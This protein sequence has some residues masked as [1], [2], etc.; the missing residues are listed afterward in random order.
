MGLILFGGVWPGV[1]GR[2]L[3]ALDVAI[4]MV[5]NAAIVV[6]PL[7]AGWPPEAMFGQ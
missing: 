4:A 2:K 6:L 7:V 1:P 5:I 3:S